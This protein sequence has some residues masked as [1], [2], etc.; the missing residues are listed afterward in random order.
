MT[1]GHVRIGQ[2]ADGSWSVCKAKPENVGVRCPHGSGTHIEHVSP[3]QLMALNESV[4][5]EQNNNAT[6]LSKRHHGKTARKTVSRDLSATVSFIQ[7]HEHD[8]MD[9]TDMRTKAAAL[10]K[11]E[12]M[13]QGGSGEDDWGPSEVLSTVREPDGGGTW[14]PVTQK[15][16]IVGFCYSPYPEYSECLKAEDVTL[17]TLDSY[18]TEH[19]DVLGE[20]HHFVG[21]WN[22]PEDG[23]V[24]LDVSV[25]TED[26]SEAA[27]GCENHDQIAY[28]D[29][30]TFSS[31]EVNRYA[32]S[33]QGGLDTVDT[34]TA[35]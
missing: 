33:G 10:H 7:E 11:K 2:K 31:V 17:E 16:P 14:N 15:M 24:Y 4:F 28:F 29:L 27:T 12:V 8:G 35:E 5:A 32:T 20:D 1:D 23:N 3:E 34:S 22:N 25:N 9:L 18:A 26:A 21:L 30:Q 13:L 6:T 19:A